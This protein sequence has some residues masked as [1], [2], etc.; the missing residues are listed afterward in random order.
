MG[1]ILHTIKHEFFEVLPPTI[2]FFLAFSLLILTKILVLEEYG[3][4]ASGFAAAV[5]GALLVGKI[6]LVLNKVPFF[7][8][9]PGKPLVYNVVWKT[10]ILLLSACVVRYI[11]H[12][13]PFF[14]EFGNIVEAHEHLLEEVAW[15]HFWMIQL[16]LSVLFFVYCA[17]REFEQAIGREEFI[18]MF[19]GWGKE[20]PKAGN[21]QRN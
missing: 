3:I 14:S 4:Q 18:F 13:F 7:N 5:I 21:P 6:V 11:E 19:F 10:G 17:I 15:P 2:F 8:K 16:W 20:W 9:Y 12:L 1:K